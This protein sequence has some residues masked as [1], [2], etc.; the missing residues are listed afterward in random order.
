MEA[1]SL[2]LAIV[3]AITALLSFH[4]NSAAQSQPVR[5]LFYPPWNI[6][7]LPM[8]MAR[9]A[10]IF[11]RSGL[12]LTWINPGSN[13]KLLSAMKSGD[14]DIVVASANHIAHNNAS[15][16]PA[17]RLVGNSGFNYSA[18][19][20]DVSINSAADLKGK[21]IGTG[22]PGSTPDQLTRLAL[23]RLGIDPAKDVELVSFNEGRSRD[24]V[25]SLLSGA[26]AAMMVTAES[27][28]DLEKTG[29]IKNLNRLSDYRR[30]KIFAGGGGDYAISAALLENR[31]EDAKKFISGICEGLALARKD[32]VKAK[33][34]IAKT[35]RN[36]DDA[37]IDYLYKLY[38]LEVIPVKPY[39]RP[40]GI[41]LA[42]QMATALLPAAAAMQSEQLSDASFVPELEKE[43]RCNF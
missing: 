19:L 33:E 10:G 42:I 24:R 3:L 15:G 37:G 29:A 30:L 36:M 9:D 35:G 18:F 4:Q 20:A 34:Y 41:E 21:K 14:A 28:Y 17:L 40:E 8:Y 13:G 25:R 16:G 32:Q 11:E 12:K 1:R 23:R 39:V 43:G 22:E 6:S 38:M 31:R 26:V 2:R 27:M 5:V 7:K